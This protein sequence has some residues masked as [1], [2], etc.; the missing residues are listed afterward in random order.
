M[1]PLYLV[2]SLFLS[3]T[4]FSQNVL[5]INGEGVDKQ[6]FLN[7]YSKN[8]NNPDLSKEALS[9]YMELFINYKLKVIEAEAL[10][11]DTLPSFV[12]ELK[13]YR[14]QLIKPYLTD[15][16]F[17]KELIEE[18]YNR[19]QTEI[20]AEHILIKIDQDAPP[21]DT[22]AVYNKLL[23]LK[24]RVDNG[25]SFEKL[26]KAYSEDPSAKNNGGDL[27]YFSGMQMVFPFEDA[28]FTTKIG[29]VSLPV[30]TRYGYHI[31]KVTD[32][33]D[34]V[35][36]VA[37]SHILI[38]TGSAANEADE[39]EA[40]AK[41]D[42]IYDRLINGE[43]FE[44]LAQKFSD[45]KGSA[46]NGGDLGEFGT[47]KMV[48][49][50]ENQVYALNVGEYSKPFLTAYGYHIVKL[51]KRIPVETYDEAKVEITKRLTSDGRANE[52]KISF[53]K[54]LKAEYNYQQND[55]NLMAVVKTV[56]DSI[57]KGTWK[58]PKGKW[59]KVIATWK[60]NSITQ[61][62]FA[63]YLEKEQRP[64]IVQ[65]R[66]A[67]VLRIFDVMVYKQLYEYEDS[68][69]EEKYPSFA[70]LMQEYHDGILLFDLTN[71]QVWSKAVKDSAGLEA[72]YNNN[73]NNYQWK[74]RAN[75]VVAKSESADALKKVK[76]M[77]KNGQSIAAIDSTL[78]TVNKLNVRIE[79]QTV[80]RG[81]DALIDAAK[82]KEGKF[83]SSTADKDNALVYVKK[84][85]P[86]QAQKLDEIRGIVISDYQNE[87]MD[88]WVS[89]LRDKYNFEINDSVL[90]SIK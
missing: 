85:M 31:I 58:L 21:K 69:L 44:D 3:S 12:R 6:E 16:T 34:A 63:N 2:L 23:K 75:A 45:D 7:I 66:E 80:E 81:K 61:K 20:R 32:K 74:Q 10:G 64:T 88:Q 39:I 33:R 27:G 50:F 48:E 14:R 37:A 17:E 49:D 73:I 54:K 70:A 11:M 89:E 84:V 42:A 4:V 55:K 24:K 46:K 60:D 68:R 8:N 47:G 18:A 5:T 83:T 30:R 65:E 59:D 76:K 87:L 29:E 53:L 72:F 9:E 15:T 40:K 19:M 36:K 22:L 90:Y 41:I 38:A 78:N 26:A 71:Q 79:E 77:L 52:A 86:P 82:W 51:N 1:K 43:K 67:Y 35:G 56:T 28:A 13:G 57:F 25:E 62:Q